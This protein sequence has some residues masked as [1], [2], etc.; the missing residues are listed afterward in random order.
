MKRRLGAVALL[1]VGSMFASGCA[2]TLEEACEDY[3]STF[4]DTECGASLPPECAAGCGILEEALD[5]KC[6]QEYTDALD[7][8]ASEAECVNGQ[9]QAAACLEEALAL[10]QC[11]SVNDDSGE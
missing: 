8:T 7:C 1:F 2:P 6:I 10:S 4:K 11:I 3:C 9:L 5:G